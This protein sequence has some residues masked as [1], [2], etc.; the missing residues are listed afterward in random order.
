MRE[1]KVFAR[2]R[3]SAD[4]DDGAGAG[5]MGPGEGSDKL[6]DESEL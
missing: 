2:P 1:A 3:E 5:K 4:P 6:D